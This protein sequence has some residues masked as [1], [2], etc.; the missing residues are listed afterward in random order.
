MKKK[1]NL[2]DV[3]IEIQIAKIP[4]SNNPKKYLKLAKEGL[5]QKY[6]EV[7]DLCSEVLHEKDGY[8]FIGASGVLKEELKIIYVF[9]IRF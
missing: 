8:I 7:K 6:P 1:I 3:D 5:K 2:K 9:S 4:F